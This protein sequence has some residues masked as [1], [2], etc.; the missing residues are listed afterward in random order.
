MLSIVR[1]R[2][3]SEVF[4]KDFYKFNYLLSYICKYKS[5]SFF[6]VYGLNEESSDV[7]LYDK[8]DI[9]IFKGGV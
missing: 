6:E 3:F 1:V 7:L 4:Y 2:R 8:N 9:I 5:L